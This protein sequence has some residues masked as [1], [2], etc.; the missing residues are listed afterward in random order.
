MSTGGD[1]ATILVVDDLQAN[2]ELL[3]RRLEKSG[4]KVLEAA[5]GHGALEAIGR[6]GVDL[7]LLDIMMPGMT[8]LD[9]LRRVR[10]TWSSATLPVIMVT[11]KSETE[12]FVEA[13]GLG[14]NDYV[15]KPVDYPVALARIQAHL[16]TRD[17]TR[18]EA[19]AAAEPRTPAQALPGS[20]LGG[21]YLLQARIGGGSYGTVYL[22]R[23]LELERPVAVKVLATSAGTDKEAM[24]RFRR[25]GASAC[26]V[27]HPNAVT[28]LDFGVNAGGV[29]YLV[30]ELLEGHS[31]DHELER[32]GRVDHVR[33]AEILVPISSAL[34]AAHE[35]GVVHRDVKPSNVFLHR[36]PL[37]EVPKIL[38]FGIA[39]IVG[40]AALGQNLTVDGSLLGTPA[41]MAPE[42]FRR[43]PFGP[44]S[45]V[46][47]LGTML[48]EMLCGRLPFMPASGDPLS[49]VAM[50]TG[51]EAAPLRQ[52]RPDVAPKLE[53]L[54]HAALAKSPEERP[55]A[56]EL[57]RRLAAAVA[58]GSTAPPT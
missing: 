29:A 7:V 2:R 4:F 6:G 23:H 43:G 8:G 56:A 48:Y 13:L 38:D 14:A 27:R 54:V 53:A 39:K 28:V 5:D 21:R 42:R 17:A 24:A 19:P 20:I 16:R 32:Q 58:G 55:T 47:S 15:T 44:P 11:A 25:E 51:E 45:D 35:A 36:G 57:A 52:L 37:G 18:R 33:C 10:E 22:A 30:M 34:A 50:Q 26:R 9:V 1:T 46:Y 31:L 49:L 3:T 12:D 40:E 41:Y